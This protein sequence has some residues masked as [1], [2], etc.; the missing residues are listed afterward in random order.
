MQTRVDHCILVHDHNAFLRCSCEDNRV[1]CLGV[2]SC[3]LP[4]QQHITMV[5]PEREPVADHSKVLWRQC[6]QQHRYLGYSE[7]N[8]HD[9]QGGALYWFILMPHQ[10][11]GM[12][13]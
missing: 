12:D 1:V 9:L 10:H 2:Q 3:Q 7:Q 11:I 4:I 8:V 5:T 6:I 13:G